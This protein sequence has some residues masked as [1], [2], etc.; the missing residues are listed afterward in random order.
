MAL[1]DEVL[2]DACPAGSKAP[3]TGVAP[4][5]ELHKATLDDDSAVCNDGSPAIMYVRRAAN[6][7]S[8]GDWVI[9][10][11]AGG[12]CSSWE[13]CR[14]RFCSYQT[15]YDA[16]KMTSTLAPEVASAS[17]LMSRT[18][19]NAFGN[20]NQVY[21]YYCSSDNWLGR[22]GNV[23]LEDP[24]G[25]GPSFRLHFRGFQIVEAV[26]KALMAGASSDDKAETL[27]KLDTATRVLFGG[28]SAG[29]TGAT[30]ALDWFRGQVPGAQV[31]GT[32][33]SI[34]DPL[35]EDVDDATMRE[36][37]Q[38]GIQH[39]YDEAFVA[40]YDAHLDESC[41][42]AHGGASPE[43]CSLGSHV[44][45]N[46]VTTPFFDRQDLSDPV[47]FGYF[48][49]AGGTMTQLVDAIEKTAKR[50][51][52]IKNSAEEKSEI[53][54]APGVHVSNCGQHIVMLNGPWFGVAQNGNATVELSGNPITVH[55]AMVSWIAGNPVAAIDTN[56]ST[57][58]SCAATTSDQ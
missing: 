37:W 46:H 45:L 43:L 38:I 13:V 39:R 10:L 12:G 33:D 25:S 34:L 42:A 16:A 47:Q 57:T 54:R 17:G 1:I 30:Q 50:L 3:G 48:S 55:D 40:L 18:A 49:S 31:V 41:V 36:S 53:A 35:P 51:P 28:S 58:S 2:K 26:V 22:R 11:Q 21:V 29:S 52:D 56:P 6:A 8:E 4:G 44:R 9:F 14:N 24:N 23:V 15:S 7:A 27:P 20:A 32:F 19:K 5:T